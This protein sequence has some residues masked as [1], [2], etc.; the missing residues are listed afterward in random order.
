MKIQSLSYLLIETTD[1]QEWADYAKDVVGLMKNDSLSDE[2]NLFLRMDE[3]S[4]R[5]HIKTGS[6]KKYLAAGFSL[7]DKAAFDNAKSEL[8]KAKVD[9]EDLGHEIAKLRVLRNALVFMIL[10]VIDLNCPTGAKMHLNRLH[11]RKILKVSLQ[12]AWALVMLF[13]PHQI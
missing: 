3:K 7:S 13:L 6:S 10:Q 5:F 2:Q 12:R 9:Y 11:Q 1:L 8:D 4:F